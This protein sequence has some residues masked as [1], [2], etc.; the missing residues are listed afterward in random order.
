MVV[1]ITEGCA[2][3]LAGPVHLSGTPQRANEQQA[4]CLT[5]PAAGPANLDIPQTITTPPTSRR[6]TQPHPLRPAGQ[7][8]PT[9]VR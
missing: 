8:Q 5:V 2:Q 3:L 6:T 1:M 7:T 9:H 4:P